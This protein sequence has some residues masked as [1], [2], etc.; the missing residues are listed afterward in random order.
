MNV[1]PR[2][3]CESPVSSLIALLLRS[4]SISHWLHFR[5]VSETCVLLSPT[6]T[7]PDPRAPWVGLLQK[8]VGSTR[9][10]DSSC[11]RAIPGRQAYEWAA[12]ECVNDDDHERAKMRLVSRTRS[13]APLAQRP[14]RSS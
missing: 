7:G 10:K 2:R 8:M 11:A 12:T 3:P 13:F 1:C 9:T 5:I 6:E 4:A 14:L